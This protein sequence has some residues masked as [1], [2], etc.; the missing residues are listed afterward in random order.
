M[1]IEFLS[2]SPLQQ[3]VLHALLRQHD[4][5]CIHSDVSTGLRGMVVK[6]GRVVE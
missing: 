5:F 4:C 2:C 6:W 3:V 1:V